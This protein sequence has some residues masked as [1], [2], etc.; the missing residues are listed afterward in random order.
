MWTYKPNIMGPYDLAWYEENNIS[1]HTETRS[2][3]FNDFKPTQY[4]VYEEWF[5]GRLD[6]RCSIVT[7][8]DWDPYGRQTNLPIMDE[9][10]FGKFSLWLQDFRSSNFLEFDQ[11]RN[12]FEIQTNQKL[13]IFDEIK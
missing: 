9:E 12:M 6:A 10:S 3:Q 11:I 4:K 13:I 5:G 8:P 1:Y 7:D 2:N